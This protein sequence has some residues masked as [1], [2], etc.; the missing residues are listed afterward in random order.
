MLIQSKNLQM[1]H[2]QHLEVTL[3]WRRQNFLADVI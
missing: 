1:S 2:Q 3:W